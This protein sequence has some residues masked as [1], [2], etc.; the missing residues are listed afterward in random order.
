[1]IEGSDRCQGVFVCF[2][3]SQ[4]PLR[5][6]DFRLRYGKDGFGKH[7]EA[8]VLGFALRIGHVRT[9]LSSGR[10]RMQD[11]PVPSS[12]S[13]GG[14]SPGQVRRLVYGFPALDCSLHTLI[15]RLLIEYFF[16]T[17]VAD[18]CSRPAADFIHLTQR[19]SYIGGC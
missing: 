7:P 17:D 18:V 11:G 16:K 9:R 13:S 15:S 19:Y 10:G 2:E 6:R 12:V 3:F 4:R 8:A 5:C 1:M 14:V